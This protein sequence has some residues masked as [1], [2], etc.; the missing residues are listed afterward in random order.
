MPKLSD[1]VWAS[2]EKAAAAALSTSSS[3]PAPSA[4]ASAETHSSAD[5]ASRTPTR[6]GVASTPSGGGPVPPAFSPA[7]FA[8]SISPGRFAVPSPI[9]IINLEQR[10]SVIAGSSR[11]SGVSTRGG[12]GR[13]QPKGISRLAGKGKAS[14]S[15]MASPTGSVTSVTSQ[16]QTQTQ[17]QVEDSDAEENAHNSSSISQQYAKP[18]KRG[19]KDPRFQWGR[20]KNDRLCEAVVYVGVYE[21]PAPGT[22]CDNQRTSR[23]WRTVVEVRF[24]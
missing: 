24:Y 9:G 14:A 17:T 4:S 12:S 1:S 6:H 15:A 16:H 19:E 3:Q 22:I 13:H 20:Y 21:P 11:P 7:N 2:A 10:D 5:Q 23:L 18:A 8:R